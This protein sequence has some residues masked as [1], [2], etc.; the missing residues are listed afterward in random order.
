[1]P[2]KIENI[3]F[4]SFFKH[5]GYKCAKKRIL[6]KKKKRIKDEWDQILFQ[7]F[8]IILL[9]SFIKK[10]TITWIIST[11]QCYC[12]EA[13]PKKKVVNQKKTT[14]PSLFICDQTRLFEEKIIIFT[15][16]IFLQHADF[17]DFSSLLLI[18]DFQLR[19]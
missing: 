16:S 8:G 7:P 10:E 14:N 2:H 4:L 3:N 5:V 15:L 11:N 18:C 9:L 17:I 13:K 19:H 12:A 6:S 1:M